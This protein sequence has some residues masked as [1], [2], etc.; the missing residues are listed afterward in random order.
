MCETINLPKCH[1]CGRSEWGEGNL[2]KSPY[3]GE[4]IFVCHDCSGIILS[5]FDSFLSGLIT[6]QLDL[7]DNIETWDSSRR[8]KQKEQKTK[9]TPVQ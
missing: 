4:K 5:F 1:F 7:S 2:V 9:T 8:T 6:D 3:S